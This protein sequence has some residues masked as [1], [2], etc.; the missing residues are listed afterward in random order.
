MG[1]SS[2]T[3]SSEYYLFVGTYTDEASDGIYLYKFNAED[4]SVDSLG[5]AGGVENPSYL[6]LSS[7]Y[8]NLYAVN[9]RADSSEASVSAFAFDSEAEKL[10]FINKQSSMG[11][12]PCYVSIDYSG[13]AVFV[14]NYLGG[15]VS[16]FPVREDGS[17]GKASV[18]IQHEGSSV[19]KDR[20]QSPHVHCTYLSPDNKY[21]LVNDLGTDKVYGYAFDNQ[22][23]NLQ[24]NPSF[25]YQAVAGAGPRHLTFH[26]SG[27]FAYL[28]NEL[29]GTIVT[30]KYQADSL[31]KSQTISTLPENYDG[32]ISGA[33]I[34][35]SPDGRFLY[36]SNREDLNNIVT[37]AIDPKDGTLEKVGSYSS[38]G[39]HP[40][41]FAIDPTGNYLLAA[42][43]NTD[44]IVIFER[45]KEN[46]A[47]S[48]TGNEIEV[49][50]PVCLKLIPTD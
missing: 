47:L 31:Q 22:S 49:S 27:T 39:V 17:L 11:G 46:G 37:Y 30:F 35:V 13:Q 14:G 10:T 15:S 33:D 8:S 1:C 4:G 9:E 24:K 26:P 23:L 40:R 42:N 18:T 6:T 29:N 34:H 36:A 45:N 3:A 16:M 50:Q 5:V 48:A 20:Q 12:A 38:G 28:I 2:T 21:L 44:N 43:R 25:T 7:D 19:N 41:N 32:A